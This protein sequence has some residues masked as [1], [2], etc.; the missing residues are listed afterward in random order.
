MNKATCVM[1]MYVIL[2]V[3]ATGMA[4]CVWTLYAI[5]V[6]AQA[7]R[8]SLLLW[9]LAWTACIPLLLCRLYALYRRHTRQVLFLL[10]AIENNDYTIHFPENAPHPDANLVNQALNRI[11]GL[12]Y[13]I[14]N[15]T[16]QQEKYYELILECIHTGIIVLDDNGAVYQKN[17]EA[18]NLLGLDVF[19]HINQLD[20]VDTRLTVH[21]INSRR[22]DTFQ[23]PLHNERGTLHLL[24]N[25]S[26]ITVHQ[27]HLR[28]FTLNDINNELDDKET[29]SWIRL[30]RVLTH[31]IMNNVT[32]ITSLSDTLLELTAQG[33]PAEEI[34]NG[35]RA[36]SQTGKS[37]LAFVK[38]YRQFTHIPT[39][40]PSLFYVRDFLGRMVELAHHQYPEAHTDIRMEIVPDNLIL[41]ADENLIG[42]VMTNLLKN[43]LQAI[44]SVPDRGADR[45]IHIR[46]YCDDNEA[47][48]LEISNSGPAIPPDLAEHVFIPFFTTKKEGSGIGLSISRQ[49]MRLS[50]GSISL[51]PG[52]P[53]TFRLKFD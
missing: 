13:K 50:G 16:V 32:P 51:L 34:G 18:L 15:E 27:R 47:V 11:V 12:L 26:D 8:S 39:P 28:I 4:G 38:S 42:Q 49:I 23:V 7:S 44:E 48:I 9:A 10:D 21:F 14:K 41:H 20:R 1:W 25:V 36:I 17:Q 37:L 45:F 2:L 31:E 46:A 5:S 35:L 43:A 29:E 52:T 22:G 19:T 24:V 6:Q 30:T 33:A 40:V 53:T 3:A